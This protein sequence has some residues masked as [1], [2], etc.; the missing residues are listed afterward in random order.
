[1]SLPMAFGISKW[2]NIT[3]DSVNLSFQLLNSCGSQS[4]KSASKFDHNIEIEFEYKVILTGNS[5]CPFIKNIDLNFSALFSLTNRFQWHQ[6]MI[7]VPRS[8]C[9]SI[10]QTSSSDTL[11][12][13]AT[14]DPVLKTKCSSF[15]YLCLKLTCSDWNWNV[16]TCQWP[17]LNRER[18]QVVDNQTIQPQ[19][20]VGRLAVVD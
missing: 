8:S 15:P 1:M 2:S 9:S 3:F 11:T 4:S 19:Q 13:S 7:Q 10:T 16:S 20:N 12:G 17:M 5:T 6:T 14:M 18:C